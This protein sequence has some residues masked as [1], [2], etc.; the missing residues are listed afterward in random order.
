[1][2][3]ILS[4]KSLVYILALY[5][6][7]SLSFPHLVEALRYMGMFICLPGDVSNFL[8]ANSMRLSPPPAYKAG[9]G[10]GQWYLVFVY[11]EHA[12]ILN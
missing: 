3:S 9:C 4:T 2:S 1:M 11:P 7:E 5:I 12:S 8:M 6:D 10:V